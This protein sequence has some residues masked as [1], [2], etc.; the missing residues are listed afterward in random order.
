MTFF[1]SVLFLSAALFVT[2]WEPHWV[3]TR[4]AVARIITIHVLLN[5]VSTI[6]FF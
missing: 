5:Q 1:I 4:R 3:A 6:S 2:K